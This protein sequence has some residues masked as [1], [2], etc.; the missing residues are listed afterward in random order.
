[1]TFSFHLDA[2]VIAG[3]AL[4]SLALYLGFSPITDKL[5]VHLSRWLN[6]LGGMLNLSK[7]ESSRKRQQQES[8]SA[9]L[10]SLI[11]TLPFLVVGGVA[12]Y[13]MEIG[14]G[15]SWGI[16]TGILACVSCGVY[17]L[18]RRSQSSG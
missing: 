14:L 11:S 17:D 15:G 4:W 10:A 9:L 6:R 18:G 2:I 8:Q 13:G 7:A 12:Y 3:S 1:M 16:S 5:I